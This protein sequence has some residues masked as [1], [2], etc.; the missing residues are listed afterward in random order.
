MPGIKIRKLTVKF[1]DKT[2]LDNLHLTIHPEE[3]LVIL[4]PTGAGKTT[5]LRTLAGLIKPVSGK[6]SIDGSDISEIYPEDRDMAYL[7]QT[8]SLFP[9]MNVK[10]N[11]LFSPMVRRSKSEEEMSQLINEVLDMVGLKERFN[12]YPNE[13]SGGMQQRVA[14]A[15]AIAADMPIFLLDEPLR[16]LDARLRIKL[17]TELRKIVKDLGITTF[18]VTHDQEEAFAVADRIL[19]LNDGKIVQQGKPNTLYLRPQNFFTSY[20]IGESN[21]FEGEVTIANEELTK[22]KVKSSD[23]HLICRMNENIKVGSE[24]NALI[25]AELSRVHKITPET[26]YIEGENTIRGTISDHIFLGKYSN[27]EVKVKN[28]NLVIKSKIS[29]YD[30]NLHPV[31]QEVF[32]TMEPEDVFIY[33]M[34]G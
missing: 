33:A 16:A 17:R 13:L 22:I 21:L 19:I 2:V 8:Y 10:E 4:G 32:I 14:L 25:K 7:P 11:V 1:G 18:Y 28:S 30:S 3:F 23:F 6:I 34:E 15:R 12:A 31:G 29:S 27:I 24:V 26:P 9:Y 20:F 5:L